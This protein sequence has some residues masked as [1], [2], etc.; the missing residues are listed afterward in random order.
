MTPANR[1]VSI[2]CFHGQMNGFVGSGDNAIV[3]VD[4][5]RAT[6]TAVTAVALGR[7]CFLVPTLQAA[8]ILRDRLDHPLVAGELGGEMPAGFDLTNSPSAIAQRADVWRPMILLSTSGTQLVCAAS[9]NV[10]L[11]CL[12]NSGALVEHL[13]RHHENVMILGAGTRGEF[14]EEDQLCCAWLASGLVEAG[15][16]VL[17]QPTLDV[18]DEWAGR[19]AEALVGG[20]STDYLRDTDQLHDLRFILEHIDDLNCIVYREGEE[21]ARVG[22]DAFLATGG[23][24]AR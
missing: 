3:A 16:E 1:R 9:G 4:V 2:A 19:P 15:Y 20:K 23:D 8:T 10:Y 24:V 22:D 5:I 6:T 11:G 17:D 21:L 14:R 13:T 7:R 12:R 18:I